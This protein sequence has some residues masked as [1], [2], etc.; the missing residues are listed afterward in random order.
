MRH[1]EIHVKPQREKDNRA[2]YRD[3]WWQF[4]ERREELSRLLP[5]HH[6]VLVHPY[7]STHL[8][9]AFVPASKVVAGP[10][11]VFLLETE[12]AFCS[13]QCRVHEIWTRFFSSSL[14]DDLSYTPSDCFETFPFPPN[15]QTNAT[16]EA[17][18]ARYYQ[19]RAD[20]MIRHNEGLTTTYNR[21]HDPD[22]QDPD[23]LELRRLHDEMDRA[24]LDAYGWTDVR[25][26]C[27]F[28]LDHEADE[29]EEDAEPGKRR[30]RLPWRWRWSDEVRDEVLARLL[31]L[32]AVR[33]REEAVSGAGAEKGAKGTKKDGSNHGNTWSGMAE[34]KKKE[35]QFDHGI[36]RNYT[37]KGRRLINMDEQDGL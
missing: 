1:L 2:A 26:T 9:F 17:I 18:G 10:H 5:A 31:E 32:N 11:F 30:K 22:E 13:L 28:L 35:K 29:G 34:T 15:W 20:L 12:A 25:P 8:A 27:R 36:A 7:T 6:R 37:E 24:V 14:K 4:A 23:I 19:H 21:F 3:R 33:A 16:L